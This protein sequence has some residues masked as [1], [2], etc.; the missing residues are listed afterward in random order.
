MVAFLPKE[1]DVVIINSKSRSVDIGSISISRTLSGRP[2]R[3]RDPRSRMHVASI[4]AAAVRGKEVD[5]NQGDFRN[6][7][8][9]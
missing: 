8:L 1:V 7:V 6:G 2:R 9:N 3:R 5:A 4:S